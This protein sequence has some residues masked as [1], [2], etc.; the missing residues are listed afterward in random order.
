[1]TDMDGF[2]SKIYNLLSRNLILWLINILGYNLIHLLLTMPMMHQN[3]FSP[4]PKHIFCICLNCA[5]LSL[6]LGQNSATL[7]GPLSTFIYVIVRLSLLERV[8]KK[9]VRYHDINVFVTKMNSRIPV[10][11]LL[12]ELGPAPDCQYNSG[13]DKSR[14]KLFIWQIIQSILIKE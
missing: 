1:M 6:S 10:A 9:T 3:C 7:F 8:S 4:Q 2:I 11:H 13:R 12:S 5:F 14:L